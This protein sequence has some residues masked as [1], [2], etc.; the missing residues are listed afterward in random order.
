MLEVGDV[1]YNTKQREL[2]LRC[3]EETLGH[4]TALEI[5]RRLENLGTPV[6]IA[7]VYRQLD[8]LVKMGMVRKFTSGDSACYQIAEGCGEHFHLKCM[9]CGELIHMDC[10]FIGEM[11]EHIKTHHGFV[12]DSSK[13]V[14]YGCCERCLKD[15]KEKKDV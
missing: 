4:V 5:V 6:G 8:R 2:V 7:T 15:S 3:V 11:D 14:L 1:G 13:T 10:D 12:V 9:G